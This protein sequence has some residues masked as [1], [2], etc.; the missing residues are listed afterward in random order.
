DA[1]V[2]RLVWFP[3]FSPDGALVLSAHGSWDQK[4]GG[5]ARLFASKD[6]AVQHVFKHPRGVRTVAWSPKGTMF[7]T[8]AYGNGLGGFD[9]KTHKELFHLANN[10]NVENLR[11][12]SNDKILAA[13]FA[14][15]D[16]RLYDLATRKEAHLF[17]AAHKGGI[18]GMALA[19][20]DTL[21]ATAGK[22]TY[23]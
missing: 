20:N 16:V 18:W 14:A 5:E 21:L 7:V 4:E 13:S 19:P 12:S 1:K 6:G 10:W 2:V 8:G 23:V 9:V 15:G 17:P 22:D 3:R 11:I